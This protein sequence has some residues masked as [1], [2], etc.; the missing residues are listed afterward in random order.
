MTEFP[1]SPLPGNI[2][3]SIQVVSPTPQNTVA[4][5]PITQMTPDAG[6]WLTP[7]F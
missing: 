1:N 4:P 5:T 2:D 3:L 6:E 7:G